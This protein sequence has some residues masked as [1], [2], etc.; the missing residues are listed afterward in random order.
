MARSD[1]VSKVG[2]KYWTARKG[3][4]Q[5]VIYKPSTLSTNKISPATNPGKMIF[6]RTVYYFWTTMVKSMVKALPVLRAPS[7]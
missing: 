4:N 3:N 6:L 1:W 2:S 7:I 5:M